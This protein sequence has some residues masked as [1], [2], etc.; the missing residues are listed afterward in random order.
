MN[1]FSFVDVVLYEVAGV[2]VLVSLREL[3]PVAL[4]YLKPEVHIL[5]D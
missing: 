5:T 1:F 3:T 4:K 2:M